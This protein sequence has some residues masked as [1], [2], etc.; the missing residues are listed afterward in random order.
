MD[1]S[2]PTLVERAAARLRLQAEG[3]ILP[4]GLAASSS[5]ASP[6]SSVVDE[7]ARRWE[8]LAFARGQEFG[9]SF[10]ADAPQARQQKPQARFDTRRLR[11]LGLI[12]W[13]APRSQVTEEFRLVKRELL[14]HITA[15]NKDTG[16]Q[17]NLVMVTSAW[18]GEG[19]TFT[20]LNLAISIAMEPNRRVLLFDACG[21][22]DS[23]ESLLQSVP[24]C[25]WRDAIAKGGPSIDAIVLNTDIPQVEL[26]VPGHGRPD[27]A[28]P[29]ASDRFRELI[30]ELAAGCDDRIVLIDAPPCLVSSDPA[31]LAAIAGTT[32]L[33]VEAN[34]TQQQ[35][36]EAATEILRA[37]TDLHLILNKTQLAVTATSGFYR[38]EHEAISS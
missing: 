13:A 21:N 31:V 35:S 28:A 16:T 26:V 4:P 3:R 38:P 30:R 32:L 15:K 6:A 1:G 22:R 34:R 33:V 27:D 17:R 23:M 8:A 7:Q 24:H 19:K 5:A 20:T 12:D 10:R 25:G 36:V 11:D 37:S 29:L 18:A 2:Q 9:V 14:R